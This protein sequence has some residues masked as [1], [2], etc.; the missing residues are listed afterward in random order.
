MYLI[1]QESYASNVNAMDHAF[2]NAL[3]RRRSGGEPWMRRIAKFE[4][5]KQQ[6]D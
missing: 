4:T 5:E 2:L 1:A 3:T 6:N